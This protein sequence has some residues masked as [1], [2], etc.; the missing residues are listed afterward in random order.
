MERERDGL[1]GRLARGFALA[2]GG[3]LLAMAGVTLA[4]VVGRVGWAQ[5]LPGDFELVEIGGAVAVFAFLPYCQLRRGHA[6]VDLVTRNRAPRLRAWLDGLSGLLMA[7]VAGLLAWRLA[8]GGLD[9][10]S[11]GE[12]SMI[13]G[14]PLWWAFVPI[15]ASLALLVAVALRGAVED[16]RQVPPR[17]ETDAP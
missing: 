17:Q 1:L 8:A 2:G 3:I 5:P 6:A 10:R 16:L 13:L 14:L 12:E 4:S 9:F 11:N 7:A 15:V